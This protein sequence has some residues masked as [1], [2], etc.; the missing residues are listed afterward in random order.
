MLTYVRILSSALLYA[1]HCIQLMTTTFLDSTAICMYLYTY[2]YWRLLEM[3][4][5]LRMFHDTWKASGYWDSRH[6]CLDYQEHLKLIICESISIFLVA[7][8]L[9]F[10]HNHVWY[11]SHL[12][13][14]L[15][16]CIKNIF[17]I[18]TSTLTLIFNNLQNP[19]KIDF[20]KFYFIL[21]CMC[22]YAL[23]H[24]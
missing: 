15:L 6:L 10:L 23:T 7:N 14:N 2:I 21:I 12:F 18:F 8:L 24:A 4:F 5:Q 16:Y 20:W 1:P 22:L 11:N 17:D 13:S 3:K 9:A 19:R